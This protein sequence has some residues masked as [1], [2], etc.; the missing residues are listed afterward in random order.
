MYNDSFGLDPLKSYRIKTTTIIVLLLLFLGSTMTMAQ[1]DIFGALREAAAA[2]ENASNQA[3]SEADAA[4]QS[5]A[6]AA[7]QEAWEREREENAEMLEAFNTKYLKCTALMTLY[8]GMYLALVNEN[9][10]GE[11]TMSSC[12]AYGMQTL[13]IASSTFIMYC[14]EEMVN[15]SDAEL[16]SI[17]KDL[18][19]ITGYDFASQDDSHPLCNLLGEILDSF[20]QGVEVQDVGDF[21]VDRGSPEE[22][23]HFMKYLIE[24]FKPSYIIPR[25]LEIGRKMEALG[26]N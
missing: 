7:W 21:S 1:D 24:F 8:V 12:D 6:A 25:T 17:G 20:Y 18:R 26:C 19:K 11:L 4:A 23:L 5:E 14:P 2:Q 10:I 9:K 16:L 3:Q 13:A 22:M 15:L